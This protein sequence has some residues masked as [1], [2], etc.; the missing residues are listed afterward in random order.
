MQKDGRVTGAVRKARGKLGM[1]FQQFNLVGRLSLFSN[2]MLGEIG[3][4]HV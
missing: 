2:V 4:A 3:R 1:I